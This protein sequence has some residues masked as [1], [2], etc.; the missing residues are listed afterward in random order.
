MLLLWVRAGFAAR[1]K[2]AMV[3]EEKGDGRGWAVGGS[4]KLDMGKVTLAGVVRVLVSLASSPK[5]S[6]YQ[7]AE[8][9]ESAGISWA[10]SG[11]V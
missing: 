6:H 1:Q 2:R 7:L 4:S 10:P 9:D 8:R 11:L 5:P 3:G